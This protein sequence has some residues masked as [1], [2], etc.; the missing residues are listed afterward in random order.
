MARQYRIHP[1]IGIARVG[2]SPEFFLGP[3][4][5]HTFAQSSDGKYR[6][7]QKRLR[8]Q[9]VRFWI[10]EHDDENPDESRPVFEGDGGVA[11][12]AWTVHLANKKAVWFMFDT[13]KGITGDLSQGVPYP[14]GW[15]LRNQGWIPAN[16]PEERAR[17]LVIDPGPRTLTGANQQIE[18]EKGNS[19]GH[20]ETWP[21]PF[22]DGRE[23]TSLGTMTTDE[24]G[25]LIVAGGFGVSGAVESDAVPSDGRLDFVNNDKWFDDVSDGAVTAR[26]TLKDG[27]VHDVAGAW[28]IVGPPDYAPP[29]SHLVTMYDLLF[30]VFVR[31]RGLRPD[32]F[33]PTTGAFRD[34][35][36]PSYTG[37]V[38]PTLRRAFDYRWVIRQ[39]TRHPSAVFDFVALGAEPAAGENPTSNPRFD[40]FDRVRDPADLNG[41]NHRAMPLLHNDG[42]GGV[43]PQDMRFTVTRTQYHMLRQWATGQ[44]EPDWVGPPAPSPDVSATGLDRAALEGGCGGGFFP[45]ME[46]SW[47][48]RDANLYGEAF[49]F[50]HLVA[51]DNATG[52]TPGDVTKRSA[53][54]WQADFLK[55]ADNWWP[56]QR[57]DQVREGPDTEAS[58][59]WARNI[60]GHVD[61]VHR[62]SLLGVVVP[63]Q[64][65]ASPSLFHES[66][67]ELPAP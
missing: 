45:G 61:L 3:E 10:F 42:T 50:R 57:P 56:A 1:S 62:W 29:I 7:A 60:I 41:P 59:E 44:F 2:N 64:N 37:E 31:E 51:E 28:V 18:I 5:P 39:A 23:I 34:D 20:A 35:Y 21:G 36:R 43:A 6:D 63:A 27:S 19:N 30:D 13:L 47:N 14:A 16:Q 26:V 33:D 55:C 65:P 22:V 38:Y 8:R 15:P 11:A 54:P 25:R 53:L 66:E 32:I 9:A 40:I 4:R 58:R 67:R 46:A 48:L 52:V 24:Q 12:I 49:R 17:R